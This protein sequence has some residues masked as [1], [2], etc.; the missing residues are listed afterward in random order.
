M[1]NADVVEALVEQLALP[2]QG[3]VLR[4]ADLALGE[5]V[6]VLGDPDRVIA[7]VVTHKAEEAGAVEAAAPAT[8]EPEVVKKGKKE[9]EGA[10]AKPAA[11]AAPKAAPKAEKKEKK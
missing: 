3:G 10:A 4:V 6:R 11:K 7:H 9:E 1:L 2:L 5:K 8:A